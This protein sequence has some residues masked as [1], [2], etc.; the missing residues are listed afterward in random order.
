MG[1]GKPMSKWAMQEATGITVADTIGAN[2]GTATSG[3]AR[4]FNGT[5]DYVQFSNPI[6]PVGAKTIRF[7]FR[8][9]GNPVSPFY[10]LDTS[11]GDSVYNG[12]QVQIKTNGAVFFGSAN[13]G[14][15][16]RFLLN[17]TNN[18]CNNK[19]HDIL[20]TWDG[21]TN[22]NCASIYIDDMTTPVVTG[23][24]TSIETVTSS[25]NLRIGR[26]ANSSG[27]VIANQ[28]DLDD[29]QIT[30]GY[31]GAGTEVAHWKMD[32]A[33][34][35][36]VDSGPSAYTGTVTGTAVLLNDSMPI[37]VSDG[38]GGYARHFNG[39]SDRIT[40][41]SQVLPLGAK[42]IKFS[43]KTTASGIIMANA[44]TTGNNGTVIN[45]LSSGKL[46]F[47]NYNGS[48]VRYNISSNKLLNDGQWHDVLCVWD[49]TTNSNGVQIFIDNMT[50]PDVQGTASAV[51]TANATNNLFIGVGPTLAQFFQGDLKDITISVGT[52]NERT[53]PKDL[54]VGDF[55]ACSY[56]ATANAVGAFS[57]LGEQPT[58]FVLPASK[59]APN[60]EG[61]Y[62]IHAGDTFDGKKILISDRNVQN[63][64]SFDSLNTAGVASGSGLPITVA[65]VPTNEKLTIKLLSGGILNTD[66]DDD[67]DAL[68][69][70]GP[71][72]NQNEMWNWKSISSWTS[73]TPSGTA[74]NR[75]IR[76]NAVANTWSSLV[77]STVNVTTGFRPVLEI[78]S[79]E[80]PFILSNHSLIYEGGQYKKYAALIEG[81]MVKDIT[82]VEAGTLLR[83]PLNKQANTVEVS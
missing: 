54:Q 26:Q 16:W 43:I 78:E 7:K 3:N 56:T 41:T 13:A 38:E 5:S 70:N 74:A 83:F 22:V 10:V 12:I 20:C 60:N 29:I 64:L 24:S 59:A 63:S 8:R 9:D 71:I 52:G 76:G 14:V 15:G 49:G 11:N 1:N 61:F 39:R 65:G 17:T 73:T 30:N 69:A 32:E 6:I 66:Y 36:L 62:F 53:D 2:T 80:A 31:M 75:V 27:T 33:S 40:F 44:Y 42:S 4:R 50:T 25:F 19:W 37:I 82:Y 48:N 58:S 34:G 45:L 67:Y 68:I 35:N 28:F 79:L 21:T 55:I 81:D 47:L 77:S 57:K 46:I 72:G 23:T 18:I 51:E